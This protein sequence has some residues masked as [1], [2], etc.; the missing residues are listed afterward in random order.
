[1][2]SLETDMYNLLYNYFPRQISLPY[3]KN[4]DREEFFSLI[5]R[6]NGK[7]RIFAS[8]YNYTGN[9]EVDRSFL[10]L[11][12]IF[13]DFDGEDAYKNFVYLV[14][15]LLDE[16]LKFICTFSGAGFHV[17]LFTTG[18]MGLKNNKGCLYNAHKHFIKKGIE[19]DEKIVGDVA[20][21][22]TVPNTYNTRRRRFCIPLT[23]T[24]VQSGYEYVK[25]KATA[26]VFKY[27]LIGRKLFD[28]SVFDM[29]PEYQTYQK[30]DLP[31]LEMVEK[32]FP[33]CI[34]I[35]LKMAE[36]KLGWRGRY[37]L[38]S[39]LRDAGLLPNEIENLFHKYFSDKEFNHCVYDEGQID[40]LFWKDIMFPKCEQIKS[41][42]YCPCESYCNYTREF[43]FN[44]LVNIYR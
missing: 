41:E 24:D 6:L 16:D 26:Q 1:M 39:Y 43:G 40:Y 14:T 27:D 25:K 28:V 20:R 8:V 9:F 3:R 29:Q 2:K 33:P 17:Y 23:L 10:N 34:N 32:D 44:H 36:T 37:L 5:N 11:D 35:M 4:V 13:F 19:I 7:S 31:E 18:Y 38:I 42:N 22:A 30:F 15:M 12:K 21:V